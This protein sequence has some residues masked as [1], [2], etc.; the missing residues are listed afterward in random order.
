M[1]SSSETV[2]EAIRHWQSL[3]STDLE[4]EELDPGLFRIETSGLGIWLRTAAEPDRTVWFR[5]AVFSFTHYPDPESNHR[6]SKAFNKNRLE[7]LD[8]AA[9]LLDQA[10]ASNP[11]LVHR[12]PTLWLNESLAVG[13]FDLAVFDEQ[14]RG[15][16]ERACTCINPVREKFAG[17]GTLRL[18][19]ETEP[20]SQSE[21]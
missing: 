11:K 10:G 2:V 7:V 1:T 19:A 5:T 21:R 6:L 8:F 12:E 20:S 18:T 9:G 4:V 14:F 15:F 17:L 13:E 16:V 3:R